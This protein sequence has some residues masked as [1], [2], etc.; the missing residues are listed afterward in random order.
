EG[1]YTVTCTLVDANTPVP[2][3]EYGSRDD[4]DVERHFTI[5]VQEEEPDVD[6]G[7]DIRAA[8]GHVD[9]D[10][11]KATIQLIATD[12]DT[13]DPVAAKLYLSFEGNKGQRRRQAR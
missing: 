7:D 2:Q 12:K 8:A 3:G 11:H 1:T 4:D 13:G 9:N 5:T 6:A 10:V